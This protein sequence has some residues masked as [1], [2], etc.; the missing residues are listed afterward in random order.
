MSTKPGEH[1]TGTYER[2]Y[3]WCGYGEAL[4]CVSRIAEGIE[5]I[6]KA[7]AIGRDT[8]NP[9]ILV[10]SLALKSAALRA[11]KAG[12]PEAELL[13]AEVRHLEQIHGLVAPRG[14]LVSLA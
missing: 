7:I 6:D 10:Q 11:T 1:H 12:N 3:F 9:C 2:H 5:A 8:L 4:L 13:E 14:G